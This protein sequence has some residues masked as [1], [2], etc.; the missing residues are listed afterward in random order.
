MSPRLLI[1]LLLGVLLSSCALG[2]TSGA[3]R[4]DATSDLGSLS[5]TNDASTGV[6]AGQSEI[7]TF[8]L[9]NTGATAVGPITI[10]PNVPTVGGV[11]SQMAVSNESTS[12]G[13]LSA[14]VWTVPSL[15]AGQVA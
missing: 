7:V 14:G 3:V 8:S 9:A 4:A 15:A 11:S 12:A 2:A 6:S 10:R 1:T 5:L 13:S